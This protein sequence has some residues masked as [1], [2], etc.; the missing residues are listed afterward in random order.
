MSS[1]NAQ[2]V[3]V[4]IVMRTTTQTHVLLCTLDVR[5]IRREVLGKRKAPGM[6]SNGGIV[7]EWS[8]LDYP[9]FT[10]PALTPFAM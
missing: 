3:L 5:Q 1:G 8:A 9:G 7:S 2:R 10:P 4:G 6:E